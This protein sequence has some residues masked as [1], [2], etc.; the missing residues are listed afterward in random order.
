M[1]ICKILPN[2]RKCE[3]AF[4]PWEESLPCHMCAEQNAE[5]ELLAVGGGSF[6]EPA[7]AIVV[8]EGKG[9]PLKVRLDQVY[10]IKNV[11]D[12]YFEKSEEDQKNDDVFRCNC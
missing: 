10:Q 12:R 5:Y 11:D 1:K 9:D 4:A 7:W 3:E 2:C 6:L 8:R